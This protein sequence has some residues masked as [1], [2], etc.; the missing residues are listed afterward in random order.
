MLV[1]LKLPLFSVLL[2]F[3]EYIRVKVFT[4]LRVLLLFILAC[5]LTMS[6]IPF[7]QVKLTHA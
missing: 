6:A 5:F 4:E 2:F 1:L 3:E 7:C